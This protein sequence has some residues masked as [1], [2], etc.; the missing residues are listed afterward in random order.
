MAGHDAVHLRDIGRQ[1]AEDVE[2][3]TRALD[4]NRVILSTDMDFAQLLAVLELSR[5]S[6]V[7]FR[8]VRRGS[9]ARLDTLLA[10]LD[11]VKQDLE[12]GS[13]VIIESSRI[14]IRRLPIGSAQS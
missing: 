1:N 11:A 6:V 10:N 13:I 9:Q 8:R 4:E 14:R 3:L 5:P 12:T 7:L 2:V